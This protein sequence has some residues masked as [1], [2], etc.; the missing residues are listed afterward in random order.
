MRYFIVM[1]KVKSRKE[2]PQMW[3]LQA[4]TEEAAEL[5]YRLR[6]AFEHGV[7]KDFSFEPVEVT[8]TSAVSA[9]FKSLRF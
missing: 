1:F 3:V 6:M 9:A 4:T 5:E 2:F 7:V 8:S